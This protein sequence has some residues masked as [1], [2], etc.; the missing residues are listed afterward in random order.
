[1]SCEPKTNDILTEFPLQS[2][3]LIFLFSVSSPPSYL[4][5]FGFLLAVIW[6]CRISRQLLDFVVCYIPICPSWLCVIKTLSFISLIF[7]H[8]FYIL[9]LALNFSRN[10]IFNNS[11]AIF[12]MHKIIKVAVESNSYYVWVG[13]FHSAN[14]I[15]FFFRY[16][17]ESQETL[18][19]FR[20]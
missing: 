15:N 1:M 18:N 16:T 19:Y 5:S 10:V 3:Q 17:I 12:D 4:R 2:F 13:F 7:F 20:A 9:L 6:R 11:H 14:S 8:Y